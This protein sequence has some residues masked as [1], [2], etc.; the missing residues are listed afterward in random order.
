MRTQLALRGLGSFVADDE[1]LACERTF[2]SVT[3]VIS[4][5]IP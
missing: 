2:M 5:L 1:E 3:H 4:G